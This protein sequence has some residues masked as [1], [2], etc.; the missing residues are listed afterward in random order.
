MY[1]AILNPFLRRFVYIFWQGMLNR[2]R[3]MFFN[4]YFLILFFG[5]PHFATYNFLSFC[6]WIDLL[7]HLFPLDLDETRFEPT[8]FQSFSLVRYPKERTIAFN[9]K[10]MFKTNFLRLISLQIQWSPLNWI[11]DNW[12]SWLIESD[13]PGPDH[14]DTNIYNIHHLIESKS[15]LFASL[16]NFFFIFVIYL[17]F[18]VQYNLANSLSLVDCKIIS[19]LT[20]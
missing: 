14:T 13:L 15:R 5:V 6:K 8:T 17:I 18:L 1:L 9:A 3:Q 12:I 4:A 20:K 7:W 16:L 19:S 2:Q 11:T 10:K